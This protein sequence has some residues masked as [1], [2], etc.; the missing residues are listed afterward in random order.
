[1][2]AFAGRR[3][4]SASTPW[5]DTE[6]TQNQGNARNNNNAGN[7]NS[8]SNAG[9]YTPWW[10][11]GARRALDEEPISNVIGRVRFVPDP[12]SKSILVLAPPEFQSSIEA[13]IRD[14]DVPGKQVMVK[15]VV[16]EVDHQDLTS[17]G[18]QLSSNPAEVFRIGENAV[19]GSR[20]DHSSLRNEA[21]QRSR[22]RT[23]ITT[24]VDFLVKKVNAQIL[25]QQSLWTEDNEEASFFKGQKVAFQTKASTFGDGRSGHAELRVSEGRHDA[26]RASQH[27]A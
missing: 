5:T 27:H 7:N 25:N 21:R 12:R 10:S 23:S 8:Q 9:E 14:L 3:R 13:T 19:D 24:L 20:A 2:L 17:L 15:A 22:S 1:M 4:A 11:S 26:R 16:I 18:L 6:G